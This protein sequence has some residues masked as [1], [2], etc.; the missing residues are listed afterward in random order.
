MQI[1]NKKFLVAVQFNKLF[2]SIYGI[3]GVPLATSFNRRDER[4][5]SELKCILKINSNFVGLNKDMRLLRED[6][7]HREATKIYDIKITL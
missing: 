2:H 3:R 6:I 7:F 5:C 1:N 4:L